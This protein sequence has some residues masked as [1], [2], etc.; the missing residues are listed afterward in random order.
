MVRVRYLQKLAAPRERRIAAALFSSRQYDID[1]FTD[2]NTAF[3][4]P[5]H[6]QESHLDADTAVLANGY[7]VVSRSSTTPSMRRRSSACMRAACG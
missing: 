4:Y 5:L 7:D 2:A 1:T 6:F 3:Q